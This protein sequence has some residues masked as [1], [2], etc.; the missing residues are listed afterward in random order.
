MSTSNKYFIP[1]NKR[2]LVSPDRLSPR[3][4][5]MFEEHGAKAFPNRGLGGGPPIAPNPVRNAAASEKSMVGATGVPASVVIGQSRGKEGGLTSGLGGQ[6][7]PAPV[8]DLCSGHMGA[9]AREADDEGRPIKYN[10]NFQVDAAHVTLWAL[11]NPDEIMQLPA[12]S[13]GERKMT[14][15]VGIVADAV[16]IQSKAAAGVKIAA[17]PTNR[18]S[19]GQKNLENPG[20]DLLVNDGED[21]QPLVKGD[22]LIELLAGMNEQIDEL[23]GTMEQFVRLQ[24]NFNDVVL[25]HNHN[26][27]FWGQVTAPSFNVMFEGFKQCFQRVADVET[28]M[29]FSIMNKET[30]NNN[31]FNPVQEKYILSGLVRTG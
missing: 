22:N 11:E 21:Q 25:A 19:Q 6:G 10:P 7:I 14:S 17:Y 13:L 4:R 23:R 9:Y 5:R 31:Y 18:N 16:N 24:G 3:D 8:I 2:P 12:G 15:A 30:G 28:G 27:P 1:Q 26:S 29:I 20:I